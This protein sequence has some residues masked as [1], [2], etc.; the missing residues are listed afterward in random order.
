MFTCVLLFIGFYLSFLYTYQYLFHTKCFLS[1]LNMHATLLPSLFPYKNVLVHTHKH[2]RLLLNACILWSQE[3]SIFIKLFFLFGMLTH[4]DRNKYK[5]N[6]YSD[7]LQCQDLVTDVFSYLPLCSGFPPT[8]P[9][10]AAK[11][12]LFCFLMMY[13]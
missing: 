3:C 10:M 2:T 7:C 13:C 1:L 4:K 5:R 12:D 8:V 9:N 6:R 11:H